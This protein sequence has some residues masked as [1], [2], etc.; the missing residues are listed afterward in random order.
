MALA[1]D[2]VFGKATVVVGSS[3]AALNVV[4]GFRLGRRTG[5]GF[6]VCEFVC[7]GANAVVSVRC[8]DGVG[9]AMGLGCN[10]VV[11]RVGPSVD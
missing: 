3:V 7:S 11:L 1:N 9:A 8:G 6:A 10:V 2:V 4:E 5:C